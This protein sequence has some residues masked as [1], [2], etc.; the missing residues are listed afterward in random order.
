EHFYICNCC[1]CSCGIMRSVAEFGNLTAVARSNFLAAVDVEEC[2]GCEDCVE[3][4]QFGALSLPEDVCVVDSVR[5]M[6]CGICVTACPTE[7]LSLARR[8]KGETAPVP[9]NLKEWEAQRIQAR[10]LSVS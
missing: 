1:T 3:T 5:C 7:A 2:I 10:G 4:C 8:P 6:G 9:A